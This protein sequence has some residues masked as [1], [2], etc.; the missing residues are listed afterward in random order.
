MWCDANITITG[1]TVTAKGG[2]GAGIGSGNG[3]DAII[4]ITGGT[5]KEAVGGAGGAGIGSG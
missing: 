1:G 5:I 4:T 3:G 2:V